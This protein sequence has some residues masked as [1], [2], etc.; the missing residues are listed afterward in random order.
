MAGRSEADLLADFS[1]LEV[2]DIRAALGF[3]A[4][5]ALRRDVELAI[6]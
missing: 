1:Y 4:Q 5:L 6:Q 3:A 2:A